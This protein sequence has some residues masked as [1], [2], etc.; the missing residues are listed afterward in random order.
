MIE[1]YGWCLT[2]KKLQAVS[3]VVV[4]FYIPVSRVYTLQVTSF[5][6]LGIVILKSWL[7]LWVCRDFPLR[8]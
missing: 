3:K 6:A 2:F 1:S 5:A 8:F 7:S 4:P